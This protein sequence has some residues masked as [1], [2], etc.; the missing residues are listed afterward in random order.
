MKLL[1]HTLDSIC[2]C[3]LIKKEDERRIIWRIADITRSLII[4]ALLSF[5]ASCSIRRQY[6]IIPN[7]LEVSFKRIHNSSVCFEKHRFNLPKKEYYFI[8][9]S[10]LYKT[11]E[12][13]VRK[14]VLEIFKFTQSKRNQ[15]RLIDIKVKSK[16]DSLSEYLF[17][18]PIFHSNHLYYYNK[19]SNMFKYEYLS[20]EF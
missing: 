13:E 1:G 16:N 2:F 4:F 6:I 14:M 10:D 17:V 9:N 12:E 5:S 3:L 20:G 7:G 8:P 19:K 18:L 11:N 15:K